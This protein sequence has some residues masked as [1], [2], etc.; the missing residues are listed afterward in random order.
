[1]KKRILALVL[2]VLM[3][4]STVALF[5]GCGNKNGDKTKPDALV[6]MS[7][8]LDGLFNPF[9]STTAAD[10]TIVSMTQIGML[11]TKLD[12]K[13]VKEAYGENEATAVLDYQSVYNK[14]KNET[15]HTFVIKNG[16]KYSDG[17]PL[18]MH[19]VM[20]NLYVYLDPVYTGSSTMYSTNIKGLQAYRTQTFVD[21]DDTSVNDSITEGAKNHAKNRINELIN[22]FKEV[23]KTKTEGSYYA[24]YDTMISAI[25][26]HDVKDGYLKAIFTEAEIAKYQADGTLQSKA[27][28]QLKKDY[29]YTVKLFKEELERDYAAAKD[30]YTEEPYK[31]ATIKDSSATT[32]VGTGFDEIISFMYAEGF[33][34]IE[35]AE[36][37]DGKIDRTKI[38]EAVLQYSPDV[39]KDKTS[40]IN[41]VYDSKVSS[42]LHVI[43]QY[44]GTATTLE[45][46]YSAKGKEILLAQKASTDGLCPNEDC[47]HQNNKGDK[48]CSK[49][50]ES[51]LAVPNISGI[52]SLGHTSNAGTEIKVN[53]NTYKVAKEH[54]ADGTV[55]TEGEYDV[56]QITVNGVDPKAVWNFAF[57]VAPQHYYA[58]NQIVSIEKNRFGVDY[59]SFD[60]MRNE[61]QSTRNVKVPLGAGAYQATN[62]RNESGVD[63]I[64]GFYAN[65]IVYFKRNE[66]F[67]TVGTMENAK[68]EKVRYQ[69]VSASNA[70][71]AL[72]SGTVHY[73]SPQYTKYNYEQLTK[74][75]DKGV[76]SMS[77]DQLGYGYIGINAG[78]VPNINI[79]K[80]IMTAM[81]TTL[82]TSYYATNT[83]ETIYWPMS[84]VSWA[85]PKD[86]NGNFIRDNEHEYASAYSFV[87]EEAIEAIKGY[88][89][90]A[91]V[92]EGD[93]S[94]KLTFTIAGANVDDHP[95]YSV[96]INAKDILNECGWQ[97]DVV[98]DTQALTKLSTGSLAVWAAAWG[99]TIDPDMYQVYHKNSTA[100]STYAWGYREI[101]ADQSKYEEE[102]RILNKLSEKIDEARETDDVETRKDLYKDAMSLLLDLA[103]EL[104]V[105]Q[106]DVLYAYNSNVIDKDSIPSQGELNPYSSPLDRIW[107]LDFAD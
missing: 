92:N 74:L 41:F 25:A 6:L 44:W 57:S 22:L 104:P 55:K 18:T 63:L 78:K 17:K 103:V 30:A 5:S 56:L 37:E 36:K 21:D 1:M 83:S 27:R 2:C 81:N 79:R 4:A 96:F 31:S 26:S 62:A 34:A 82:A 52:V 28:E 32:V 68:I 14:D 29:E 105:Y 19:D 90:A 47:A 87:R 12:G 49:C 76:V 42:E 54:N 11:T 35:Y 65:N 10:G 84:Q 59:G 71:N 24:D 98:P 100:T 33:V 93:S 39:V 88:M 61:I 106:R 7:D 80:A 50:G 38:K 64:T 46:E 89:A 53:N 13:D 67:H 101:L 16:I 75:A 86:E 45:T 51:L 48:F 69:V 3:L 43:L 8:E 58:P 60:F 73:I 40:A 97:I 77:T 85:Y 70:L 99:S 23:G 95:C 107:E 9:F 91:N 20:F 66:N 15:V 94:L 72:E 102:N